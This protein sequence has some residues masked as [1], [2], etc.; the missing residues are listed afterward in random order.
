MGL[1]SK[2]HKLSAY[3]AGK[4]LLLYLEPSKSG[5]DIYNTAKKQLQKIKDLDASQ[6][7]F[8]LYC[9]KIF[10]VDFMTHNV[11][12]N[13][14][15]KNKILDSFYEGIQE[16][17][18]QNNPQWF[19]E[20]KKRMTD[21]TIATMNYNSPGTANDAKKLGPA[22]FVGKA[23]SNCF[24]DEGDIEIAYIGATY[25]T[26]CCISLKKILNSVKIV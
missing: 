11:F 12:G 8:E 3:E 10:V 15:K 18:D 14:D 22:Y 5:E 4:A 9:L 13:G 23:F 2:K 26:G 21:Y 20:I 16:F 19:D 7:F 1:F 6:I 24:I 17:C 25:F